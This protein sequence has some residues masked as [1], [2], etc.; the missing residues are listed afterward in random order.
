LFHKL[1][2]IACYIQLNKTSTATELLKKWEDQS[3]E[4]PNRNLHLLIGVY[5]KLGQAEKAIALMN[6][7][8]KKSKC[9]KTVIQMQILAMCSYIRMG[10]RKKADEM[11]HKTVELYQTYKRKKLYIQ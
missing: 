1:L 5:N 3:Y 7:I 9:T 2:K 11:F 6:S 8:P 4:L 10:N